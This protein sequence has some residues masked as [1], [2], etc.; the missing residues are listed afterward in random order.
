M[1]LVEQT[2]IPVA[3]LPLAELRD[4]LRFGTGF[5]DD[6]VQDGVLEACLR[7]AIAA[8]EGRTGK[9]FLI[10]RFLWTIHA[11]RDLSRQIL[12]VAPV[13]EAVK[14]SI[15]DRNDVET[16]VAP[17]AYRVEADAHR[18]ALVS[19]GLVLPA[20]P[21]AGRAEIVFD[22]GLGV[23]WG[24][25]P[26]AMAHAAMLLAGHYY[27]HRHEMDGRDGMPRA[28]GALIAPYRDMRL[29]AGGTA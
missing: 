13:T 22:A 21:V 7:A 18:P 15:F 5:A 11:W 4:Q 12:P 16:V 24:A 3:A 25:V 28:V 19:S 29:F 8:I 20:I 27:E 9:A 2:E 14:L 17:S 23:A 1:M 6:S 10:R 26:P